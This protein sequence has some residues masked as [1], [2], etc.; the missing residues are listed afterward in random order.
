MERPLLFEMG[1]WSRSSRDPLFQFFHYYQA[2]FEGIGIAT[3]SMDHDLVLSGEGVRFGA[4]GEFNPR[5][6]H[7]RLSHNLQ[8]SFGEEAEGGLLCEVESMEV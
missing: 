7:E 5:G 4:Q 1:Y 8:L 3:L 2:I 6:A